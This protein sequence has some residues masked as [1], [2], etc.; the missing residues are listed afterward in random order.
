M[1]FSY[2][3]RGDS[4]EVQVRVTGYPPASASF[5]RKADCER[6]ATDKL[7]AMQRGAPAIV[8]RPVTF[9]EA[10]QEFQSSAKF[11]RHGDKYKQGHIHALKWWVKE[12]GPYHLTHITPKLITEAKDKLSRTKSARGSVYSPATVVRSMAALAAV[13]KYAVL[14]GDITR[15]PIHDAEKPS[16]KNART[17][18][19]SEQERN[20]LLRACEQSDC[21]A[22]HAIVVLAISTGMRKSEI[23]G[24]QWERVDLGDASPGHI[25]LLTTKN[26]D[27]RPVPLVGAAQEALKKWQGAQVGPRLTFNVNDYVFP[28][29][30]KGKTGHID[31]RQA[32]ETALKRA[33][34]KDF[35]FHDLR[36]TAASNFAMSGSSLL[37]IGAVLGHR[38]VASTKRY[39]HLSSAHLVNVVARAD[40]Q[41]L[42][43]EQS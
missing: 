8:A 10:V 41:T 26:G 32:W 38:S 15:S 12:L 25:Q 40:A 2:R 13:L 36:H 39:T 19:L 20:S 35:R 27:S 21:T 11:K 33:A 9:K 14:N 4:W 29:P 3:K 31:I 18:H 16:V 5:K 34:L 42:S 37:D 7:A 6:W 1:A 24:L 23:L 43:K 28:S 22:L 17:R 30:I